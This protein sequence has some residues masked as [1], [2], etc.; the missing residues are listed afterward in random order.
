MPDIEKV[1]K[2][3]EGV[4]RCISPVNHTCGDCPYQDNHVE[5]VRRV[6]SEAIALLKKDE[7]RFKQLESMNVTA[8]GNGTAIGVVQGGLV[9]K[10]S[11]KEIHNVTGSV[12]KGKGGKME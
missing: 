1:I 10:R 12:Q 3:L 6:L 11:E 7:E 8:T 9:I 4:Y 2:G 5:C